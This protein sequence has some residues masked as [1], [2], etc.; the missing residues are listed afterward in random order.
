MMYYRY[1]PQCQGRIYTVQP[2][3]TIYN[4]ARMNNISVQILIDANPQ[5]TNPSNIRVGQQICI[6]IK[7][8]CLGQIYFVNPGDTLN[9]I[10]QRFG[11]SV[12]R[13]LNANPNITNPNIL[14]VGQRI[15]IPRQELPRRGCVIALDLSRE[16]VVGLPEIAGGAVLIQKANGA[17]YAVTFVGVGLPNPQSIGD[18]DAYVGTININ[19]QRFSA[20]LS[21][22]APFEQE[23]TWA[24]TRIISVN[25]FSSQENTV[26]IAP[27]NV[28]T[29]IVTNPILGG[30]VSECR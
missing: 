22:S 24:G 5:I 17:E 25:P 26:I 18:F 30:T 4:I 2:G 21:R 15:C 12:A 1:L 29:G 7:Q 6:P 13:I 19:G 3:D 28:E 10:A 8:D 27:I 20:I 23:P 14:F 16:G 11:A 9:T